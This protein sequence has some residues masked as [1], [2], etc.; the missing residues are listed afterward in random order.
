MLGVPFDPKMFLDAAGND[1][2]LR[3]SEELA[4]AADGLVTATENLEGATG[5]LDTSVLRL[6]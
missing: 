5:N 1:K 2:I 4:E 3:T 6:S